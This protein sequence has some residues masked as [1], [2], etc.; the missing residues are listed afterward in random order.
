MPWPGI[1]PCEI[2]VSWRKPSVL[3][4]SL[5]ILYDP[6]FY[7]SRKVAV[8]IPDGV[9]GIFHWHNPSG[10]TMALGLTQ[11]LTEMSTRNISL[12]RKGGRYVGLIIFPSSYAV[13]LEIWEPQTHE[14]LWVCPGLYWDCFTFT[15]ILSLLLFAA[16]ASRFWAVDR[17]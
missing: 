4:M 14:T 17:V 5:Q 1:Y 3:Y 6:L 7:L 11:P 15:F 2:L 12:G 10:S 13:Y 9:I 8:S 16:I